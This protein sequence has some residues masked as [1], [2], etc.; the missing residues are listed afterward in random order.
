MITVDEEGK[1]VGL[2]LLRTV[3]LH[4]PSGSEAARRGIPRLFEWEIEGGACGVSDD[5]FR[6]FQ[7]ADLALRE[8]PIDTTGAVRAVWLMQGEY[9]SIAAVGHGHHIADGVVLWSH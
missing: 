5:R 2:D 4:V 7:A 9:V 8:A 1:R 3:L 6:A